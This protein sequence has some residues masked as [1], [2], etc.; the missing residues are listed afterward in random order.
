M[1]IYTEI[2]SLLEARPMNPKKKADIERLHLDPTPIYQNRYQQ[3]GTDKIFVWFPDR[4]EFVEVPKRGRGR[5]AGSGKQPI[6]AVP[7]PRTKTPPPEDAPVNTEPVEKITEPQFNVGNI[8]PALGLQKAGGGFDPQFVKDAAKFL[9]NPTKEAAQSL[10]SKYDI[11]VKD[12][13]A[14]RRGKNAIA[15]GTGHLLGKMPN[16][17]TVAFMEFLKKMAGGIPS[18]PTA[19]V[20]PKSDLAPNLVYNTDTIRNIEVVDRNGEVAIKIGDDQITANTRLASL[21]VEQLRGTKEW[22]DEYAAAVR[23]LANKGYKGDL[24]LAAEKTADARLQMMMN[25]AALM[26]VIRNEI[27]EKTGRFNGRVITGGYELVSRMKTDLIGKMTLLKDVSVETKL[28]VSGGI[29]K[30]AAIESMDPKIILKK[31]NEVYVELLADWEKRPDLRPH[32][33]AMTESLSAMLCKQMGAQT[34]LIPNNRTLELGDVIAIYPNRDKTHNTKGLEV[35]IDFVSVKKDSGGGGAAR[36]RAALTA[37][38][39]RIKNGKTITGMEVKKRM[40]EILDTENGVFRKL[41]YSDDPE[42]AMDAA[43]GDLDILWKDFD[44]VLFRAAGFD[45]TQIAQMKPGSTL[46]KTAMNDIKKCWRMGR[47]YA[48]GVGCSD[49]TPITV[50]TTGCAGASKQSREATARYFEYGRIIESIQNELTVGQGW[51]THAHKSKVGVAVA[52]GGYDDDKDGM[53]TV[54][55]GKFM[56][57]KKTRPNSKRNDGSCVPATQFPLHSEVVEIEI[58]E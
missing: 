56:P 19:D 35:T 13:G 53:A 45:K 11:Y 16:R 34:L 18:D 20:K 31:W 36:P 6:K 5:P 3:L 1:S 58:E 52:D 43:D 30:L 25:N 15:K 54:T 49:S 9:R 27:D 51:S 21:P 17:Y 33:V 57:V 4:E 48:A 40:M 2:M 14:L 41:F 39:T 37:Y 32:L 7:T 50:L 47:S 55:Q 28:A 8:D 22:K 46:R 12:N 26:Q 10:I 44:D 38:H 23:R 42:I 29:K 24:K